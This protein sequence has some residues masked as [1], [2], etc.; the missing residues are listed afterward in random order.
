MAVKEITS[1]IKDI[2]FEMLTVR[3]NKKDL[4]QEKVGKINV[5]RIGWGLG[6]IDKLI[7][8]FRAARMADKLRRENSHALIWSIM[9][10]YSGF[11]ALFFK[12]KHPEA[13]FLLT[14]QEGD[15][16]REVE[17]KARLAKPWFKQIFRRADH[18]Q[19]ISN[20]LAGWAKK[21]NAKCPIE[22]IPNGVNH[23]AVGTSQSADIKKELGIDGNN[24]VILTTSRL[25]KK[26]GIEDLIKAFSILNIKYSIFNI[27]LVI[28]GDGEEW[29]KLKKLT[30]DLKIENKV[31]FKGFIEP[32]ELPKYYEAADIFCRPSLTEG[33]GN[34]FLE[35]M[36]VGLPVI[37]T[38]VG[39]ILDFLED[40]RTGWFCEVNNPES[41]AEKID[42]ILDEKNKD[43][44]A[45]V[46]E[47]AKKMVREKYDW[48]IIAKQMKNIFKKI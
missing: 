46:V 16:L 29:N 15:D 48:D 7:F 18:I 11:A 26:N 43:E 19:C 40:G 25:V 2:E 45:Q 22:V 20:Y 14:L 9:A 42:Y 33:L 13:K 44:A 5:Y 24:K 3:L 8:P 28:C 47:N 12:K 30:K 32:K 35:A 38:P 23:F 34:S 1:R 10:S 6:K 4:K 41:I 39:G 36:A 37:A 27:G 17:R 31:E 21:M